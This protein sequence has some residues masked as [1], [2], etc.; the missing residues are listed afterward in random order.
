MTKQSK[1]ILIAIVA[2]ILVGRL[3]YAVQT[4]SQVN[5]QTRQKAEDKKKQAE[6]QHKEDKEP[7]VLPDPI[8]P[9]DA[10][11]KIQVFVSGKNSCHS[12]TVTSLEGLA[13]EDAY[14]GKIRLEYLDTTKPENQKL[15]DT[16]K[17]GCS[18]GLML[19]GKTAM[20]VPGHGEMGLVMFTGP[21]GEKNYTMDDLKAAIDI[22]LKEKAEKKGK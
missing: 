13:K 21:I 6:S 14:K 12:G 5:E 4:T 3:I 16:V 9:P 7:V 17:L 15:A 20:R 19:N 2:V 11:A 8:G 10:P 22:V 1:I 18:A